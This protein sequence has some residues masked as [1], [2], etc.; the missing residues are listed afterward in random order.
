M[1][2]L[3]KIF[4]GSDVKNTGVCECFFDPK[5]ITGAIFVPKNKVFTSAE[6]LDGSIAATL[7][8]ATLAAKASRIF[9]FQGFV[10]ITPNT[11]DPTRQTFGYGS[12]STVREGNYDW[13][14]QF[15][16]GGLNLSN[17]LRTFNGLTGKYAVIF[18][19]SQNTLIG[20]SKL[21]ADGNYG[22]AGIPMEDIYTRPWS[23]SDGSNVSVYATQLT[24]KPAYINENIAFKKV[25]TSSYL[26]SELAGIEDIILELVEVDGSD[27]TVRADS[28]CGST[29]L[30][31][32]YA[33]ELANE[34]AW[35]VKD[36]DGELKTVSS[37]TANA[38]PKNWTVTT[39]TP[40]EDGDTIQ[41]AAP[42]V[43]A[44]PP[45]SITG[46]ESNILTVSIGS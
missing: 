5:L 21:D 42:A 44:A 24:F 28:D 30:F 32:L 41:L 45:V 22:L 14:F 33:T 26:L 39:S 31:D 12:I 7:L 20:T 25:A 16:Q 23:P 34:E 43:L 35:I 19:E 46:Y 10:N 11:E 4:C 2:G 15:V 29:D 13:L 37:V 27:A 36:A 3:N 8:A 17:A 9:P 18:I 38:G 6:L 40:Y 1:E